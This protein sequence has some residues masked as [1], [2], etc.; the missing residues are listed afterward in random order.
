LVLEEAPGTA[1]LQL[2]REGHDPAGPLRIAAR[3]VAAF[4][5]DDV[6]NAAVARSSLAVQLG[7]LRRGATSVEGAPAQLAARVRAITDPVAWACIAPGRSSKGRARS[8]GGR[9]RIGPGRWQ[10][11]WRRRGNVWGNPHAYATVATAP[12]ADALARGVA[13]RRPGR[14]D[15]RHHHRHGR[16]AR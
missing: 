11:R 14:N 6:G 10:R 3:A 8:F 13:R 7:E 2:L 5:Q 12:G 1:L 4:N 15:D 9:R 16:R